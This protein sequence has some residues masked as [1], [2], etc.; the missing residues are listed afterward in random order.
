MALEHD[1]GVPV[2]SGQWVHFNDEV[3]D[4]AYHGRFRIIA[5]RVEV[6]VDGASQTRP[7]GDFE[8]LTVVH[9]LVEEIALG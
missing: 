2:H 9:A 4:Q 6:E 3:G 5:G 7:L 8:P 1:A